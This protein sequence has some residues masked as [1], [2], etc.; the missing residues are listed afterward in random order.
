[1]TFGGIVCCEETNSSKNG[2]DGDSGISPSFKYITINTPFSRINCF[3]ASFASATLIPAL[4]TPLSS[5]PSHN[6]EN[7][8]ATISNLHT[9]TLTSAAVAGGGI[10]FW[11]I[12]LYFL[13]NVVFYSIFSECPAFSDIQISSIAESGGGMPEEIVGVLYGD[14]FNQFYMFQIIFCCP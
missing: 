5:A 10:T 12:P 1:M 3:S 14:V 6:S 2:S 7:S 13:L 9:K 4:F 8:N 11:F